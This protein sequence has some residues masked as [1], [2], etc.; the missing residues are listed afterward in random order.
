MIHPN[1]LF[2]EGTFGN[3][4]GENVYSDFYEAATHVLFSR[5]S[6]REY[7]HPLKFILYL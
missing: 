5:F 3:S 4:A 2:T 1:Q 6:C 7:L